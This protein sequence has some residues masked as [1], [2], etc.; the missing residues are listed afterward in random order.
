[1]K[2]ATIYTSQIL[3]FKDPILHKHIHNYMSPFYV[4]NR[5]IVPDEK[6]KGLTYFLAIN[7]ERLQHHTNTP[8]IYGIYNS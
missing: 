8:H 4:K 5:H 3:P 2:E 7:Q 1:L 6:H